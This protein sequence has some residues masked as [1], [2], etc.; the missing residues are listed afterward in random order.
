MQILLHD[1]VKNAIFCQRIVVKMRISSKD[2]G[3]NESFVKRSLEKC[4]FY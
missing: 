1:R 2:H 3:K 4:E